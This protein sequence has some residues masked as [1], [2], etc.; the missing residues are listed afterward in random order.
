MKLTPRYI[1]VQSQYQGKF[2]YILILC[3][4]KKNKKKSNFHILLA[5]NSCL[6]FPLFQDLFIREVM[7]NIIYMLG[8]GGGYT[9]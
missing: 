8:A 7:Y 3:K 1:N 4:N 6:F 2:M 5:V 9:A